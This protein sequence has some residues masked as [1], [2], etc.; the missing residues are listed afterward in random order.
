MTRMSSAS[1]PR[2]TAAPRLNA[3][4]TR[5]LDLLSAAAKPLSAYDVIDALSGAGRMA[6]PTA[7]RALQ[8]LMDAGLVHR[9][10]SRNAYVA[11]RRQGPAHYAGFMI[12]RACG[13]TRE[14]SGAALES[15]SA[16]TAR[17]NGFVAERISI[18]IQ[19]LCASCAHHPPTVAPPNVTPPDAS[20]V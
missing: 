11:C 16:Q 2:S 1:A 8:K 4:Q 20:A 12:C 14:F 3:V 10:D 6:P 17:K 18:E 7:Y 9:V 19:G 13:A 15:F 5:I